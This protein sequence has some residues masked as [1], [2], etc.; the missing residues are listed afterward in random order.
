[1]RNAIKTLVLL[2]AAGSMVMGCGDPMDIPP[3]LQEDPTFEAGMRVN[4]EDVHLV[5][6]VSG[7]TMQPSHGTDTTGINF[8]SGVLAQ[9]DCQP[10]CGP[11]LTVEILDSDFAGMSGAGIE[12]ALTPGPYAYFEQKNAELEYHLSA[13]IGISNANLGNTIWILED[14]TAV[15]GNLMQLS[16]TQDQP[17]EF[18][19]R[20]GDAASGCFYTQ[21]VVMDPAQIQDKPCITNISVEVVSD[22]LVKIS[23]RPTGE[24]PFQYIWSTGAI[25][26]SIFARTDQSQMI[27]Y[28]LVVFDA[29]GCKNIVQHRFEVGASEITDCSLPIDMVLESTAKAQPPQFSTT[30]IIYRDSDGTEYFSYLNPQPETTGFSIQQVEDYEP[31]PVSGFP[32]KRIELLFDADLW[33]ANGA[34]VR[35]ENATAIIAMSYLE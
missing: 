19:V 16:L 5:A 4:G 11:S 27:E 33:S 22:N 24:G 8:Y 26:S 32:T 15:F 14:G 13:Q 18:C 34:S 35:L 30:R 6:G 12:H 17:F 28:Q 20:K 10:A 7:Y 9:E 1:M 23:A 2:L 29:N 3:G 25:S 31:D 21:C